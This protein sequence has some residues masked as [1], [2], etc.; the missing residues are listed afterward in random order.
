VPAENHQD[1]L[2]LFDVWR[3]LDHSDL[4][5]TVLPAS[6]GDRIPL[7]PNRH[8]VPFRSPHRVACQGYALVQSKRRLRRDLAGLS[9][10]AIRDLR[11]TGEDV[12]EVSESVEVAFTG[13]TLVEVVERQPLVRAARVLIIEVT[14]LDDRVP[15][16][17]ARGKGH[18]HLD[19]VV[20]RAELF[21]NEAI[22][23]THF[24]ARYTAE[25]IV[26]ILDR[27]L[28]ADLRRRVTP[29]LPGSGT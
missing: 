11:A 18:V 16:A 28:P 5:A 4:A 29:L 8:A 10:H 7:G 3:R 2:A 13:D 15:V 6:P 25:E 9:E 24:S 22:L 20:E 27:R 12:S 23:F 14:F 17:K 26:A 19:E 1:L 21:Q